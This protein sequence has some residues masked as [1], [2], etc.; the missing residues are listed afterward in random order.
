MICISLSKRIDRSSFSSGLKILNRKLKHALGAFWYGVKYF[1]IQENPSVVIF[2]GVEN[3][4]SESQTRLGCLLVRSNMLSY[5]NTVDSSS[6]TYALVE[7]LSGGIISVPSCTQRTCTQR[8]RQILRAPTSQDTHVIPV[9]FAQTVPRP[10]PSL[11][12]TCTATTSL[13]P[14]FNVTR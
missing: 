3:Y 10:R 11:A 5:L 9:T 12:S 4:E 14:M 8:S 7:F 13:V 1:A 6:F 2:L